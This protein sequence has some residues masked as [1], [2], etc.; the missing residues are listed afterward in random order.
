[1]EVKLSGCLADLIA[2]GC[3]GMSDHHASMIDKILRF[4]RMKRGGS[5]KEVSL[6]FDDVKEDR[7]SEH[8]AGSRN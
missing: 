3:Q 2:L 1:M 7:F 4:T 5:I 8:P 6:V